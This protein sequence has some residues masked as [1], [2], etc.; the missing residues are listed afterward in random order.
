MLWYYTVAGVDLYYT[1]GTNVE[2]GE[3]H[4][5]GINAKVRQLYSML[6][7]LFIPLYSY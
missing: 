1:R 5:V 3:Y 7:D 6:F 2:T 4:G